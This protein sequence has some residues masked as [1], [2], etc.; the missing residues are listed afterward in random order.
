MDGKCTD[1]PGRMSRLICVVAWGLVN[2]MIR[3]FNGAITAG[4]KDNH[5]MSHM[6][7]NLHTRFPTRSD[8]N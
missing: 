8:T 2:L 5:Y 1:Q 6:G 3:N 4:V 7:E